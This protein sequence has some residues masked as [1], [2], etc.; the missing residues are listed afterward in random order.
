LAGLPLVALWSLATPALQS[1]MSRRVGPDEQG[2]LQGALASLRAV[3][4]MGGPLLFTQ[5]FAARL[6]GAP[7]LIAA[8]LLLGSLALM[9]LMAATPGTEVP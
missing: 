7:Y 4:G 5:V 9:G 1:L 3:T 8:G 6:S 2:R